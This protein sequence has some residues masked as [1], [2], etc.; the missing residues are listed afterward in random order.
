[1]VRWVCSEREGNDDEDSTT[2]PLASAPACR[3]AKWLPQSLELLFSGRQETTIEQEMQRFR[4]KQAYTEEA[5][6]MELL[7]DKEEGE[8]ILDD[9]E[10]DGSGDDFDG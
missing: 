9:G 3:P 5:C 10:L 8:T 1:M 6:L 4:C 2:T 7:V